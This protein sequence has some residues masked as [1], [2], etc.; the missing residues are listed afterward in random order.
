MCKK[1][2]PT[3]T[4]RGNCL[5]LPHTGYALGLRPV[6]STGPSTYIGSRVARHARV[7]LR[8]SCKIYP[9]TPTDHCPVPS[10]LVRRRTVCYRT[11]PTALIGKRHRNGTNRPTVRSSGSAPRRDRLFIS[12]SARFFGPVAG[13]SRR[14]RRYGPVNDR[15]TDRMT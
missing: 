9:R 15:G 13:E 11:V 12:P 6:C 7:F 5:V 14:R 3:K 8:A 4:K 10:R 1:L 2:L